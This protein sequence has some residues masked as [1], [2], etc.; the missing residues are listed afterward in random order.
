MCVSPSAIELR[1]FLH[2]RLDNTRPRVPCFWRISGPT[3]F[4]DLRVTSCD[5]GHRGVPAASFSGGPSR[6]LLPS[7][8]YVTRLMELAKDPFP[9]DR[10]CR[11]KWLTLFPSTRTK[12][13]LLVILSPAISLRSSLLFLSPSP[14]LLSSSSFCRRCHRR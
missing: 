13:E 7:P 5:C 1:C 12:R 2:N 14:P 8:R 3:R 10:V 11:W 6:V 9:V 4:Q